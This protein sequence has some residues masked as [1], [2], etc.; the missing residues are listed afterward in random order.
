[1][2]GQKIDAVGYISHRW[3]IIFYAIAK[4]AL[5]AGSRSLFSQRFTA[6]SGCFLAVFVR[7]FSL[8]FCLT[9][10]QKRGNLRLGED[11][12]L[13]FLGITANNSGRRLARRKAKEA[14]QPPGPLPSG[15]AVQPPLRLV[16][17]SNGNLCRTAVSRSLAFCPKSRR[18]RGR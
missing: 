11:S 16:T 3:S 8:L 9:A 7:C 2:A 17:H 4:S 18:H 13:D 15:S 14:P 10:S 5:Q 1:M 6:A 12:P